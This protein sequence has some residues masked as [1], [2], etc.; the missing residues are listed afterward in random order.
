[1]YESYRTGRPC[2]WAMADCCCHSHMRRGQGAPAAG[3]AAHDRTRHK[4]QIEASPWGASA[5]VR[6]ADDRLCSCKQMHARTK[7]G[8]EREARAQAMGWRRGA[9]ARVEERRRTTMCPEKT[10]RRRPPRM[11]SPERRERF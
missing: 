8:R 3:Q 1:M 5:R 7:G 6:M 9:V 10:R 4:K 2:P 11:T